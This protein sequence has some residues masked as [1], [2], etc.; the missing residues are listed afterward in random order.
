MKLLNENHC[1][2]ELLILIFKLNLFVYSPLFTL[3]YYYSSYPKA[4][5]SSISTELK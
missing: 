5:G 3:L 2:N 4:Q 1:E